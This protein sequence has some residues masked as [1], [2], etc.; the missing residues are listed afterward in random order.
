MKNNLKSLKNIS[1]TPLRL[2]VR[3]SLKRKIATATVGIIIFIFVSQVISN[4]TKPSP[5]TIEKVKR[6]SITEVVT[7][8]GNIVASGKNDVYSP[9]NGVVTATYVDNGS[10]VTEGQKLYTVKSSATD[11]EAQAANANYL[12][13]VATLNAAEAGANTLRADMYTKW[14]TFRNLATN[15]TY[16]KGDQSPN[17]EHRTSAEFQSTQDTWLAAE[18]NSK[19]NKPQFNKQGLLLHLHTT[20]T[21]QPKTQ[22]LLPRLQVPLKI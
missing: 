21:R 13:A 11:Q 14:D 5:Y 17:T 9:T 6:A 16:E 8:S 22:S 1:L 3:L 4:I 15:S 18:K 10:Q 2:F 19:I 7:E 20:Y 12:S